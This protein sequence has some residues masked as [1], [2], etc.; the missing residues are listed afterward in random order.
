LPTF[1][2]VPQRSKVVIDARSN[3]HPIH[4]GADGLEGDVVLEFDGAGAVDTSASH[5]GRLR[6]PVDRLRS[7]N[8]LEERELQRRLDAR[9]FPTI[10]GELETLEAVGEDGT[11]RVRGSVS[12]RGVERSCE[13][14]MTIHLLDS[15]T[16]Q[17][18]G[19]SRF[20]IRQFGMEPPRILVL[21]VEPE[22]EVAVDIVAVADE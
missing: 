17:L 16:V 6:L 21:R 1:R 19:K 5:S 11:Y 7:G 3:V 20:D 9:R 18:K 2:I 22:V 8:R 13:D 15:K 4:S 10:E 14:E 12:F